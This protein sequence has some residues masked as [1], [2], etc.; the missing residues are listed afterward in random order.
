V[1]V[2]QMIAAYRTGLGVPH[3]V[4]CRLLGVSES[5]FYKWRSRAPTHSGLRRRDLDA[6]VKEA[7]EASGGTDGSPRVRARLRLNGLAAS[8]K[9]VEASM[10]RQGLNAR[11]R[12]RRRSLT[13][14]D[15]AAAPVADLL[16]RDFTAEAPDQKW[17]GDFKQ[18]HT[19]Q[20]PVYLATV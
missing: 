17:V 2:A 11:P 9:T 3:A 19:A 16:R 18:V 15:K 1:T 13:R 5:W 12:R 6:A 4:S 14:P 20:G 10:A 7:F 8:K